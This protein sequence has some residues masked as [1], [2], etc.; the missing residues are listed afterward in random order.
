MRVTR[1]ACDKRRSCEP[2]GDRA[3]E[4]HGVR[5]PV[6]EFMEVKQC[7]VYHPF[8]WEWWKYMEIPAMKIVMTGGWFIIV[9]PTLFRLDIMV[10]KPQTLSS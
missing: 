7:H 5:E 9:L 10:Y 6:S 8:S 4:I 3:M 1:L 2:C